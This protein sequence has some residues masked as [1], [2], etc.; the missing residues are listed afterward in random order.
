MLLQV[1]GFRLTFIDGVPL[2]QRETGSQFARKT[3]NFKC[4][5]MIE[6]SKIF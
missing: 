5:K 2:R 6:I 3:T 1:T 4:F